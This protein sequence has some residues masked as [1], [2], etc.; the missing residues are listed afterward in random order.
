MRHLISW[1]TTRLKPSTPSRAC[2]DL[3]YGDARG[4]LTLASL[5]RERYCTILQAFRSVIVVSVSHAGAKGARLLASFLHYGPFL[6]IGS[7]GLHV[8]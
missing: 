5:C 6:L 2:Q 8:S 7:L 3:N 4:C 1:I